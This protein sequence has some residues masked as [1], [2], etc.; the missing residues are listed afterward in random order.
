MDGNDGHKGIQESSDLDEVLPPLKVTCVS[1]DCDRNLHCFLKRRG[2][3]PEAIGGCRA[4]GAKLVDWDKLH[5]RDR[6]DVQATFEALRHERIRHHMW[7]ICFDDRAMTLARKRGKANTYA[8]IEGRLK[9][10]IGKARGGFDGRQT[11]MEGNV[12]FY[13]QHATATCCRKC[14]GYWHGIPTDIPLSHEQ[15]DYC[16]HLVRSY[17]DERLE[18]LPEAPASKQAKPRARRN[19]NRPA[20]GQHANGP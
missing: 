10:S 17:L 13:A 20:A 14:L 5:R 12:I 19:G 8:R 4:C 9:S 18:G 15:L 16:G 1:V 7:H 2:M 6:T 3:A 11:S